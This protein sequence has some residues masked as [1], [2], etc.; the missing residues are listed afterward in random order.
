MN[1]VPMVS[2]MAGS[3]PSNSQALDQFSYS[4]TRPTVTTTNTYTTTSIQASAG[5]IDFITYRL[6]DPST[7]T[8]ASDD[9]Y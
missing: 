6:P 4:S 8:N 5:Y 3:S 9:T 1:N 7:E 2:W